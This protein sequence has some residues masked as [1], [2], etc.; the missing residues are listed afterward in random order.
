MMVL[1]CYLRAPSVV[2]RVVCGC[3]VLYVRFIFDPPSLVDVSTNGQSLEVS[4]PS[5]AV[6]SLTLSLSRVTVYLLI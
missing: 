3:S 5:S 1:I 2:L 6:L 4:E